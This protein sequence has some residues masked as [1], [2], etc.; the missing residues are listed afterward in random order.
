MI[1]SPTVTAPPLPIDMDPTGEIE[2][3]GAPAGTVRGAWYPFTY[4]QNLTGHPAISL[5]CGTTSKGL[6]VGLQ[7]CTEWYRDRYMLALAAQVEQ[8]LA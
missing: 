6:P 8:L 7:L 2:I 5:P 3:D 4:A 1:V